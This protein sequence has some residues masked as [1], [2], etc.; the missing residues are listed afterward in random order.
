VTQPVPLDVEGSTFG[1]VLTEDEKEAEP[2][3][4]CP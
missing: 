1:A 2:M 4:R 3:L